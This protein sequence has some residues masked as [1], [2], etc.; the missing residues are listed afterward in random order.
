MPKDQNTKERILAIAEHLIMSRG[1]NGFSYKDISS[2]L[3]VKNAAIHYHFPSKKNLGLAVIQRA[4]YQFKKWAQFT[5]AQKTPLAEV[6]DQFF[7][8]YVHFMESG[9]NIC[10][11]GSLETD[12][13]TLP[14]E[15]QQETKRY[16]TDM[17]QWMKKTLTSGR[18]HGF[19]SFSGSPGDKALLVFSSLQ[20]ALQIVRASDEMIL[21]RVISQ[22]KRELGL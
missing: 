4:N 9:K 12:F 6:M 7:G 16:V 19:I 22:I 10:L 20:G 14:E 15:M 3:H 13:Y 8:R 21:H 2:E 18:K 11:G 1:Y 17:F 5:S